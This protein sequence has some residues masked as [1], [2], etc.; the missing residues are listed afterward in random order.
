MAR[1]NPHTV[2]VLTGG[3]VAMPWLR[4]V[5]GLLEMWE[6]G[7]TFGTAVATLL[8]GDVNLSGRLSI[9]FPAS[10][11]QGPGAT[12]AEYPGLTDPVTG[13]SD[14]YEQLE[15]ESYNEGVDVGYR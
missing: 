15:Q 13:A 14:P 10:P 11:G 3:T 7:A 8:Y 4:D 12:A 6:P 1:A 2:V 9:T 5:A